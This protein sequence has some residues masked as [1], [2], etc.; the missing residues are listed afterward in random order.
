MRGVTQAPR[1]PWGAMWAMLVGFA[2]V[3]LDATIVP[4]ANPTIMVA[5][6]IDDYDTLMWV[7]SAYLLAGAVPLLFTGRLGDRFGPKR[8]YLVGLAVFTAA[9]L[10]CGLATSVDL[11]I[12]A[13]VGQG[14]GSALLLPQTMVMITRIFPPDRRGAAMSFWGATA[15][16][17]TF[18]GPLAG[19]ILV[20]TLGWRWIFLV[21]VPIGM[22]GMVLA[23]RLVPVQQT[24][25]HPFDIGGIVLSSA[26]MFLVVFGLQEGQAN[27]WD[28][29]TWATIV[30]GLGFMAAF[31]YW[32]STNR[33]E[34]LIPLRVFADRNFS[35]CSI[36][37]AAMGFVSPAMLLPIVFYAQTVWGLSPLQSALLT[38]PNPVVSGLVAPLV[39]RIVDTRRPRPIVGFGFVGVVISLIWISVAMS[40]DAAVW[41]L[42]APMALYG[43]ATS[44][45]WEPTAA[46]A[47]RGLPADLVGAAAGVYSAT[48][49]V[50]STLGSAGVAVLMSSRTAHAPFSEALSQVMLLPVAVAVFGCVVSWRLN[51][52]G[53]VRRCAT[54]PNKTA[55]LR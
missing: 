38:S 35:V 21:N 22:V 48:R 30:A 50:G 23:L 8:V 31:A 55:G 29:W 53:H 32:Q 3:L 43:V 24:H 4:V 17:A 9:S 45:V 18:V 52:D 27:R 36:G 15:A 44:F 28:A 16:V 2:I 46:I 7:T 11:L 20:D 12:V 37:I 6:G 19:G 1:S 41:W 33:N 14:I 5:L 13:R 42:L 34:P 51:D 47:T 54:Q 26:G 39:G 10:G 49:H 25:R 40:W